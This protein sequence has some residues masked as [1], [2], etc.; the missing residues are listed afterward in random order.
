[1]LQSLTP[2][3]VAG[4]LIAIV[5]IS[6][7]YSCARDAQRKNDEFH[8]WL[9]AKPMD[10]QVDLSRQGEVTVPFQQT[11]SV[12]H[13]QAVYVKMDLESE[14]QESAQTLLED[15][16]GRV[17][18]TDSTGTEVERAEFD[19]E[20][21]QLWNG[22]LMLT[23]FAPFAN[24]EYTATI[25]VETPAAELPSESGQ[26]MYCRYQLCGLEQMPAMIAGGLAVLAGAIGF[27]TLCFTMLS[28][29]PPR[30]RAESDTEPDVLGIP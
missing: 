3:R 27:F 5:S 1:M 24:G 26:T 23:S 14:S 8:Q 17:V 2:G 12:S 29:A 10:T 7:C 19:R 20:T 13:G 30:D 22:E 25:R 15:L 9:S 11:C 28:F 6:G 21:M 16:K 4:L 18:I